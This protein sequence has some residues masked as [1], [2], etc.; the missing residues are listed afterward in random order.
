MSDD[1]TDSNATQEPGKASTPAPVVQ[2]KAG[3]ETKATRGGAANILGVLG[4]AATLVFGFYAGRWIKES[5]FTDAPAAAAEG[6]YRVDLRG[7]EPSMGPEDALITVIE[8]SDFQC[9]YCAR[10]TPSLKEAM[11]AYDG[12]VRVI[13]K[14]FPLRMHNRAVPAAKAA[15]A[16]H[17]QGKFWEMHDKLFEG[18]RALSDPNFNRWANEIGLDVAKFKQ[19][20]SGAAVSKQLDEDYAAGSRAGC[21]GTPCFIVN[22]RPYSGALDAVRW[23][24]VFSAE[25]R[26]A[27]SL[28]VAPGEVYATLMKDAAESRGGGKVGAVPS[29]WGKAQGDG[30]DPNKRYKVL[31]E[32]RPQL[33]P[34]DALVTIVEFSDFQCPYCERVTETVERVKTKYGDDVRVVFR[35]HPLPFHAAARPAAVAA[36]A[37]HRQGKFWEMHDR[38]FP[39]RK[40]LNEELYK[41][42]AQELGLDMAQFDADRNDPGLGKMIDDDIALARTMGANGTPAF[43]VNGR[44][45]SGAV[46]FEMFTALVDKELAAAK[47][48]VAKGTPK[49]QVLQTL[50]ADAEI[51]HRPPNDAGRAARPTSK[52]APV[53][54][55]KAPTKAA[56]A[57]AGAA[58]AVPGAAAPEAK[59]PAEV[60]AAPAD[61]PAH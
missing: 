57:P 59:A 47:A 20:F 60:D 52:T 28:G 61:A 39:K 29:E 31:P 25:K 54:P 38:L 21:T 32:G 10:A 8:F 37:A 46:P 18:Q 53:Q 16:A 43:F 24:K 51:A 36:M 34:D 49:G 14:Q 30:P 13:F 17:Q 48:E 41:S 3:E 6:R 40:E 42:L 12:D 26:A 44:Y 27:E 22:G 7:D 55:G 4:F 1:K 2:D 58:D 19:D 45:L 35:H 11:D 9:P 23:K 33:G 5:Y 50:L 15:L 56:P